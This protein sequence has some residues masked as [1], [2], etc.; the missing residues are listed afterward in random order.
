MRF[1]KK[2]L[3]AL[4][5]VLA[6]LAFAA[7]AQAQMCSEVCGPNAD[8]GQPCQYNGAQ[9][10]WTTC[11]SAGSCYQGCTWDVVSEVQIGRRL[12]IDCYGFPGFEYCDIDAYGEFQL[13][14][15][16]GCGGYRERCVSRKEDEHSCWST[17]EDC[18]YYA[19]ET[20]GCW[21]QS[22]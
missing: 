21:G 20:Y 6:A 15:E 12:D 2:T 4:S 16:D 19:C 9:S 1:I 18:G 14:E 17:Y 10:G 8:C 11:G 3:Y 22:C 13:S 7:P 5:F